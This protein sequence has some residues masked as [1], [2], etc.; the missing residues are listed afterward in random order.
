MVFAQIWYPNRTLAWI[1]NALFIFIYAIVT[2]QVNYCSGLYPGLPLKTIQ[3][4][5]KKGWQEAWAGLS[6][7]T[8]HISSAIQDANCYSK[9]SHG[10]LLSGMV[11]SQCIYSSDSVGMFKISSIKQPHPMGP[12]S[13]LCPVIQ[14]WN[15]IPLEVQSALSLK[16][17]FFFP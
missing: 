4:V 12:Q 3:L 11:F 2:L 14:V 7:P 13:F 9:A 5:Q 6:M 17:L 16:G 8:Y 1:R 10:I 15:S